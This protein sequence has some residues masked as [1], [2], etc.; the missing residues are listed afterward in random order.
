MPKSIPMSYLGADVPAR[1][2]TVAKLVL[3]N[4]N[5]T[6]KQ[7]LEVILL[8]L[9]KADGQFMALLGQDDLDILKERMEEESNPYAW[10]HEEAEARRAAAVAARAAVVASRVQGTIP[11]QS[12]QPG[13]E[14]LGDGVLEEGQEVEEDDLS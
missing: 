14:E 10:V 5:I 12:E 7:W 9:I 13:G 4:R 1:L 11:I 3:K 2:A 6:Y 8:E